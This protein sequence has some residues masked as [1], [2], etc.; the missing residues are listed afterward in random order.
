MSFVNAK[1]AYGVPCRTA[2]DVE[3]AWNEGKDFEVLFSGVPW[4]GGPYFSYRDVED[5]K[6][7]GLNRVNLQYG[8][9]ENGKGN[10]LTIT[11]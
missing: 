7:F 11:L 4:I 6:Q 2:G 3:A 9:E 5:L 10:Y 8:T 1:R